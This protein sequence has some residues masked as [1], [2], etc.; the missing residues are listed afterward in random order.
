MIR[1]NLDILYKLRIK[2]YLILFSSFFIFTIWNFDFYVYSFLFNFFLIFLFFE[3][4]YFLKKIIYYY[5]TKNFVV[6][7]FVSSLIIRIFFSSVILIYFYF[8]YDNFLG[9]NPQD[10]LGYYNNAIKFMKGEYHLLVLDS[11]LGASLYYGI[12]AAF[13]NGN[14]FLMKIFNSIISSLIPVQTFYISRYF[15]NISQ[16]KFSGI[17][18]VFFP[19]YLIHT[20]FLFKESVML[21]LILISIH[22][23][24][25]LKEKFNLKSIILFGLCVVALF[26][27]R[28]IV[29]LSLVITFSLFIYK[30]SGK[31]KI[32]LLIFNLT[33]LYFAISSSPFILEIIS[34]VNI[35]LNGNIGGYLSFLLESDGMIMSPFTYF[36]FL[37]L[38]V[39]GPLPTFISYSSDY[40]FLLSPSR[41]IKLFLSPF[42]YYGFYLIF[43]LKKSDRPILIFVLINFLAIWFVG[44]FLIDI[45]QFIFYPLFILAIVLSL[46]RIKKHL[47]LLNLYFI[48]CFFLLIYW[49][50]L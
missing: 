5:K 26:L 49:N 25:I 44:F 39:I 42:I 8:S 2:I 45:F 37:I 33:F 9:F 16:A 27:F 32:F 10:E 15:L 29:A 4:S 50:L 17:L 18:S 7:L 47:R 36:Q 38:S 34:Y 30:N 1:D 48:A 13:S 28:T 3:G 20:G 6:G 46:Q 35:L 24:L 14:I 41:F 31:Y 11:D 43:K 23:I 21:V 22:C 19:C 12:L 40:I